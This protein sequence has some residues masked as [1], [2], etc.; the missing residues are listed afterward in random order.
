M[1]MGVDASCFHAVLMVAA[2]TDL[3]FNYT[4]VTTTTT[5]T[6][7]APPPNDGNVILKQQRK[8]HD[9]LSLSV[10]DDPN[11]IIIPTF[12][13][14][15]TIKNSWGNRWGEQGYV[16]IERGKTWWGPINV[17]YTE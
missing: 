9:S 7:T 1:G 13:D 3:Y 5:T 14:F 15:F 17:I 11:T 12:V 8:Q 4:T 16:R 10:N 6:A 2:G